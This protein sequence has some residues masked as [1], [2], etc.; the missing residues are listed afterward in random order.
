[1][2]GMLASCIVLLHEIEISHLNIFQV[3]L[4]ICVYSYIAQQQGSW[5]TN[6]GML[7]SWATE[8]GRS[9]CG[10]WVLV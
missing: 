4:L 8:A 9:P 6:P 5:E 10:Y 1:M 2:R 7:Y 3:L